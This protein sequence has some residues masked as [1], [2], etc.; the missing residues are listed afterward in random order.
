MTTIFIRKYEVTWRSIV[1]NSEGVIIYANQTSVEF[2]EEKTLPNIHGTDI[3]S[4]MDPQIQENARK[5]I[6]MPLKGAQIGLQK[7]NS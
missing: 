7:E 1:I 6:K 5:Q 2:F 4:L 3:V